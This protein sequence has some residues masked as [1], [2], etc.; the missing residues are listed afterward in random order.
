MV[1]K[2]KEIFVDIIGYEGLYQVSNLGKVK[3]M[4]YRN[5]GKEK[6]MKPSINTF[7]YQF[8]GLWRNGKLKYITVHRLVAMA[9]IPNPKNLPQINHKDEDKTNNCVENLEWC[10]AEYNVNYGTRNERYKKKYPHRV[11]C[12][13]TGEI[14]SSL[15]EVEDKKGFMRQIIKRACK[16]K[17]K[18]AFGFT[19]R[20][21]Y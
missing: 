21:I 18:K 7:G 10:S 11:L 1:E 9:F 8:V 3:S 16:Y 15:K 5:T 6:I 2:E 17:S 20:N 19:W 14:F 12:V 13:E 4:N